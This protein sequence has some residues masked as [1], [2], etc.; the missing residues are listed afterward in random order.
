MEYVE[1]IKKAY[2]VAVVGDGVN[3]APALAAGDLSVA[4]GAIGSDIA[5]SSASIALMNNDLRR[6]PMLILLSKRLRMIINQNLLLG[7]VFVVGGII[8]SVFGYMS[9]IWAAVLHTLSTLLIIFNSARLVRTGEE[10]T[11]EE[12]TSQ[13]SE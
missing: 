10:L 1:N 9:P 12:N 6:I 5:I 13:E 4:M 11:F 7:L 3:D 2:R 8:L